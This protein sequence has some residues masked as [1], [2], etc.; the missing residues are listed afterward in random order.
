M[1]E[2][3]SSFMS[4]LVQRYLPDPLVFVVLLTIIVFVWGLFEVTP[5]EGQSSVMAIVGFWGDGF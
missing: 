1:V 4:R 5:K 2:K 3:I